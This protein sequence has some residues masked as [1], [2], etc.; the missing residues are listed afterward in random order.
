MTPASAWAVG[1][2][3]LLLW[4]SVP[5]AGLAMA[6]SLG[7]VFAESTYAA[8]APNWAAQAVGQDAINVLL[9]YPAL[10][11]LAWLAGRGSLRAFLAWLGVVGYSAYSYV[12]YAGFL[13]FSGWFLVYVAV[14]GLS[15]F[16]VIG[17]VAVLDQ[18]TVAAAFSSRT[19]TRL[20]GGLL[21]GLGA[22]FSLLWLSEIVP[23]AA[24]GAQGAHAVNR[25]GMHRHDQHADVRV[26]G[27]DA[28]DEFDAGVALQRDVHDDD[29]RLKL[30]DFL[31]A[32]R[33][34]FRLLNF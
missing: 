1:P 13:H 18:G 30:H 20:A 31:Q 27:L 16:A 33:G 11:L 8:E 29:F 22:L 28:L 10:L 19:P 24:A 3:R 4:L 6:A 2:V 12:L 9:A 7:G 14:L 26:E 21:V 15:V 17:G 32:A 5:I 23:A 25:L 34:V